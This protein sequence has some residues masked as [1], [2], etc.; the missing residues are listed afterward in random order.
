MGVG[1]M[2]S[3][4]YLHRLTPIHDWQVMADGTQTVGYLMGRPTEG[5]IMELPGC[6]WY[7]QAIAERDRMNGKGE[8]EQAGLPI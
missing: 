3:I 5:E 1:G 6:H 4:F 7:S 2:I 8:G